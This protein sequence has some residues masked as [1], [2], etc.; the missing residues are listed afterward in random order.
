MHLTMWACTDVNVGSRFAQH[1]WVKSIFFA[2]LLLHGK[3]SSTSLMPTDDGASCSPK[4]YSVSIHVTWVSP[5]LSCSHSPRC[6]CLCWVSTR[7][8]R[9]FCLSV[10]ETFGRALGQKRFSDTALKG[11]VVKIKMGGFFFKTATM[12][13]YCSVKEIQDVLWRP[14]AS[15]ANC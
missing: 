11:G 8:P 12:I 14:V 5:L 3:L 10:C 15:P 13:V 9:A 2:L 1:V 6:T 4:P 7:L